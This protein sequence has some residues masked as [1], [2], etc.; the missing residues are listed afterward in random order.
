MRSVTSPD[1]GEWEVAHWDELYV[2]SVGST[3]EYL[4]LQLGLHEV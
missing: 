1:F 3:G 4:V 2:Y